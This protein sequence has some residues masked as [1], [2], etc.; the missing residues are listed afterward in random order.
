MMYLILYLYFTF[1]VVACDRAE[2]I[3]KYRQLTEEAEA[4]ERRALWR[5]ER[6][7]LAG[8]RAELLQQEQEMWQQQM[9]AGQGH[10]IS[11][12]V[13]VSVLDGQQASLVSIAGNHE[14]DASIKNPLD[15]TLPSD[16]PPPI[17]SDDLLPAWARQSPRE[18]SR[19]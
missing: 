2:M 3:E 17:F 7:K 9:E 1:T 5:V 18:S 12:L 11:R 14:Q 13:D 19:D 16:L 4:R 6:H 8:Q 10:D 15:L